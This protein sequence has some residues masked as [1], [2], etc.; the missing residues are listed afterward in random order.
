MSF[1]RRAL[2]ANQS[3]GKNIPPAPVGFT[4]FATTD[5][6]EL[7]ALQRV[8]DKLQNAVDGETALRVAVAAAHLS[9][10]AFVMAGMSPD[11]AADTVR[12]TLRAQARAYQDS[13]RE[14][15]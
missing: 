5:P 10:M 6:D 8:G 15:S 4:Q 11:G 7:G 9:A 13:K 2:R 3:F 12:E 14:S 1:K